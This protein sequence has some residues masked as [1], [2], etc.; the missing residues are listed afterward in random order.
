MRSQALK[1]LPRARAIRPLLP[2]PAAPRLE[3]VGERSSSFRR[4]SDTRGS[5]IRQRAEQE[6]PS[7]L[8]IRIPIAIAMASLPPPTQVSG[9]AA[10]PFEC[11]GE[12]SS[13]IR[14]RR[15]GSD[16]NT[17]PQC[18]RGTER[19]IW[20]WAEREPSAFMMMLPT[21]LSIRI[22][23]AMA[24]LPQ[25]SGPLQNAVTVTEQFFVEFQG[26]QTARG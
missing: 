17:M 10:S 14:R 5:A 16:T 6:P 25:V 26:T 24:S 9:P 4:Q 13:R 21:F 15:R 1:R 20:Q 18:E 2:P 23:I 11:V 12:R 8:R 7:F 22:T 3:H 19:T